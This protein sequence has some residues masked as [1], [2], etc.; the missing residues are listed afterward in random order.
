MAISSGSNRLF[1][2]L[3]L[4]VSGASEIYAATV[5]CI[6]RGP[7]YLKRVSCPAQCPDL[8]P[9]DPKAKACYLNCNSPICMPE[10]RSKFIS[11][12]LYVNELIHFMGY[13][14]SFI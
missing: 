10:C 9:T 8:Y 14:N 12:Q 3:L 11:L 2:I 7:C 13:G 4:F 6:R 1:I 5:T